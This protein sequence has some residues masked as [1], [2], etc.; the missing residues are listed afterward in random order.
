MI[1]TSKFLAEM[2]GWL[3]IPDELHEEAVERYTDLGEYLEE[4]DTK[5]GRQA[6]LIFPQG[7]FR[8]GTVIK[9]LADTDDYDIDLAYRRELRKESTTQE[10]LKTEAG[11]NLKGFQKHKESQREE[12]P[13]LAERRRCWRLIYKGRF[14]MDVLP[15]LPNE[16]STPHGLW[17]TDRQLRAW[18]SSNPIEYS[19]WFMSRMANVFAQRKREYAAAMN[20]NVEEVEDWRVKTPLQRVVQLLKRHR[21]VHFRDDCERKPVSIIITTLAARGYAGETDLLVALK[22]AAAGMP[23]HIRTIGG[24]YFVENPVHPA[25]NFADR[26]NEDHELPKRFFA[27]IQRLQRDLSLAESMIDGSSVKRLFDPCFGSTAVAKALERVDG[28]SLTRS[29]ARALVPALADSSHAL[30]PA[31]PEVKLYK[32]RVRGEVQ[33]K[34]GKLM[35]KLNKDWLVPKR[36]Q[37]RFEVETDAPRPY[38]V[39][40]QVTNTGAEA[41]AAHSLRG[42]FYDGLS[43]SGNVRV[44]PTAYAGTHWVE[45]FIIKDGRIVARSGR[46][47]VK[48]KP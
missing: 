26:W 3:D 11:A 45:A 15:A 16:L 38:Q 23:S 47:Q 25:E 24:K 22:N 20:A 21:D 28:G 13:E 1:P 8:I 17:I 32:A 19:D 31:W 48:I 7:S 10:R 18:Q 39:K 44:E 34:R 6:P 14:H 30:A 46:L 37:L 33:S 36:V 42:D 27:W 2:A 9:P 35:W 29:S 5:L 43:G 4:Q 41:A 40:W 12:V